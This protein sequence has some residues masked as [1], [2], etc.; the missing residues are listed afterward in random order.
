M[1]KPEPQASRMPKRRPLT[2]R[3]R[4]LLI[5]AFLILYS[6]GF[7]FWVYQPFTERIAAL[8]L[9]LAEERSKLENARTILHRLDEIEAR[10]TALSTEMEELDVLVPGDNRV[11]HFLYYCWQWERASGARV[12]NIIFADPGEVKNFVEYQVDFTVVGTYEAQVNFLAQLE[13]MDRLVRVDRVI[14]VPQDLTAGDETEGDGSDSGSGGLVSSLPST[15]IVTSRYVVHL[16]VDPMKAPEAAT[17][18]P[19]EGLTFT[20]PVGRRT[21]FLP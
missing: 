7:A 16:F 21:P 4:S 10:I 9:Q 1:G 18:P 8:E 2:A 17:E 12:R 19:G 6:V 13:G 20:L 5:V 11:A 15:D 3:E 14:L